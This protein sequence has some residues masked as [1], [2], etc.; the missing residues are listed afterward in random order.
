MENSDTV[1]LDRAT[2]YWGHLAFIRS[3]STRSI[4]F[5][6]LNWKIKYLSGVTLNLRKHAV[7]FL[8]FFVA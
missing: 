7:Q 1:L 8:S 2:A 6:D 3:S 5:E 4:R